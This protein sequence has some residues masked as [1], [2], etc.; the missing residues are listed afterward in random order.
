MTWS[1]SKGVSKRD[2]EEINVAIFET[3][4]S[5]K[6]HMSKRREAA[7]KT[8]MF[9]VK[10]APGFLFAPFKM[11]QVSLSTSKS[12]LTPGQHSTL[13]MS[14]QT[15]HR[16]MEVI[17]ALPWKSKSTSVSRPI[18]LST[19]QGD[20][21]GASEVRRGISSTHFH[22]AVPNRK[23]KCR[24]ELFL[25]GAGGGCWRH[26]YRQLWRGWGKNKVHSFLGS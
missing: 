8:P 6:S 15:F 25:A 7:C 21:R 11:D 22:C 1:N 17:P 5:L 2:F 13:N 18:K 20:A 23:F 26:F 16:A 24:L 12:T 14:G 10:K 19:N 3:T 4:V 9:T